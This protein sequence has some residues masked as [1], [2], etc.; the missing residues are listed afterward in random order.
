M[1]TDK[2]LQPFCH[3]EYVC[4]VIWWEVEFDAIGAWTRLDSRVGRGVDI[5][6][7]ETQGAQTH[8]TRITNDT[9]RTCSDL[10]RLP[11]IHCSPWRTLFKALFGAVTSRQKY[12]IAFGS[13]SEA[14]CRSLS[15]LQCSVTLPCLLTC[16]AGVAA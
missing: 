2:I 6:N 15:C 9:I 11:N 16:N 1:I 8:N 3:C 10:V 13:K 12:P 7:L 4:N 5:Y 14:L